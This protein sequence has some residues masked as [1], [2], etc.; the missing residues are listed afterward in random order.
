MGKIR[1]SETENS[2]ASSRSAHFGS[3]PLLTHEFVG[4]K[5]SASCSW[6][7]ASRI[8]LLQESNHPTPCHF[9]GENASAL[10][11]PLFL[12]PA[13]LAASY[14]LNR[15][16]ERDLLTN[17]TI[18]PVEILGLVSGGRPLDQPLQIQCAPP[19]CQQRSRS[20][21]E[22]FAYQGVL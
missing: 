13:I 6:K 1:Q 10:S 5:N 8:S 16:H 7:V 15:P 3:G 19:M 20:C 11:E 18:A 2:A 12:S 14:G 9:R 4:I 17:V 22:R 21:S